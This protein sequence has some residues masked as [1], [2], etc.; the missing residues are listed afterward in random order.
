MTMGPVIVILILVMRR[1]RR[2]VKV[3][4]FMNPVILF[5]E[6]QCLFQKTG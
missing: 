1:D 5:A 3:R 2:T 4:F 6:H